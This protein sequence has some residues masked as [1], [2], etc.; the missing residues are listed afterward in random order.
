MSDLMTTCKILQRLFLISSQFC[1]FRLMT[2]NP[3]K[4]KGLADNGIQVVQ[5]KAHITGIS[6]INQRYLDTK[7][8]RM[9]HILDI[10]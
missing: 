10:D 7:R 6:S 5:R 3:L 1:K 4:V 8:Q 2:N 9:G